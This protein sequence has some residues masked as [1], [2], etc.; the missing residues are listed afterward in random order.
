K[1]AGGLDFQLLGIGRTGHI[2][3]NEPGSHRNSGTRDITLDHITRVDASAAFKGLENV[4]R[5]AITMGIGTIKRAR[6][7]VLLAWGQNK[8]EIVRRT[9]E[10]EVSPTVPATYL[11]DHPNTTVVLDRGAAQHLTRIDT[12]WLVEGCRW[13][14]ELT[15]RAVVWLSLAKGR[16]VLQLTDKDYNDSG[17]SGLLSGEQSSYELNIRTFNRLQRTITGWPGGKPGAGDTD[18]PERAAPAAKRVLVLSPH[19]DDDVI[20]MGG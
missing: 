9:I 15:H 20:S 11:Q 12:P 8:S 18:R 6:R 4:P 14:A 3:F 1:A 19:P 13:D 10:G 7:I 16:P 5:K 2:G 17:M